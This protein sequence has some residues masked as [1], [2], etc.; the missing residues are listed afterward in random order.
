MNRAQLIK[1]EWCLCLSI[2]SLISCSLAAILNAAILELLLSTSWTGGWVGGDS[3]PGDIGG[4][5]GGGSGDCLGGA[6]K[7]ASNEW[8]GGFEAYSG[9]LKR[10]GLGRGAPRYWA[11]R[12]GAPVYLLI[13]NKDLKILSLNISVIY[14]MYD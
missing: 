1:S 4:D 7:P 10:W 13:K 6:A 2:S 12:I 9:V 3:L 8:K 5:T 14:K 11:P